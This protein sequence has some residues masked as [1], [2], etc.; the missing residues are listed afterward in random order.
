NR[1]DDVADLRVERRLLE[2]RD[3][4]AVPERAELAA[5]AA[6]TGVIRLLLRDVLELRAGG[7]LLLQLFGF[8]LR[9]LF[10]QLRL[11][12]LRRRAALERDQDVLRLDLLVVLLVA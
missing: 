2:L 3:H 10:G 5:V 9:L 1:A 8:R 4:L 11:V 12:F 6:G 7:D